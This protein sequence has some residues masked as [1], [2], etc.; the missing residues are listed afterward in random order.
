VGTTLDPHHQFILAEEERMFTHPRLKAVIC[1]SR[2]VQADVKARFGLPD[3]KLPVIY[4]A[5]DGERFHPRERKA[6]K[7]L[8]QSLGVPA[9]ARVLLYV[10]GGYARK[11]V[12]QIIRALTKIEANVHAV[13][14]GDDKQASR[15]VD[16]ARKLDVADRLHIAGAVPDVVPYYGMAD[17]FVLPTL[18]DPFPNAA[19][20][21]LATGVP[22]L[23]STSCGAA[24]LITEGEQGYCVDALDVDALADRVNRFFAQNDAARARM[25]VAARAASLPFT[26]ARMAAEYLALYRDLLGEAPAES[27]EP[28][29]A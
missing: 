16:L 29:A 2:M 8:R 24:E 11:G 19:L 1:N 10:G 21:A 9:E 7:R 5:V 12:A 26:P 13:I 27:V 4:N 28:S 18:Y 17:L 6:H 14:V 20:E 23:T 15:Y 25:S 3:S 22:V